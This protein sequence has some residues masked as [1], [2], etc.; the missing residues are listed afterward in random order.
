[1]EA[2]EVAA[3]EVEQEQEAPLQQDM[4]VAAA[5][6]GLPLS[7]PLIAIAWIVIAWIVMRAIEAEAG[8]GAEAA[9]ASILVKAAVDSSSRM[10]RARPSASSVQRTQRA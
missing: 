10:I 2:L 4:A 8:A 9:E 1:M 6:A 5:A 3:E 7:P